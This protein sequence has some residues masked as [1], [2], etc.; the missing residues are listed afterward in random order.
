MQTGKG[1]SIEFRDYTGCYFEKCLELFELNCPAYFAEEERE[2]FKHFLRSQSGPY[3]LGFSNNTFV[4]CFGMSR[5]SEVDCSL[6][7]IMV[8]PDYQHGGY[9]AAMMSYFLDYVANLGMQK[10]FIATS[11]YAKSFFEKYGAEQ[12]D[13]IEDGWGKGMHRI[14]MELNL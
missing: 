4:C 11:Q 9:G 12:L 5:H 13:F 3:F 2:D 8:H 7:W 10:V 6:N 1:L 14:N